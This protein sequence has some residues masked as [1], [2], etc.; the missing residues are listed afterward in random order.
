VAQAAHAAGREVVLVGR[1]MERVAQ[2]ARETGYL[3]GVQD[4]RSVESYG[5]LPPD[6][7]LA[8][9]TGSQGEPRAALAR[10]AADEHPEVALSAG[11]RVIFSSRAIPGN[12]KAV[13]QVINGLVEQGIEV[14]TDRTHL[15]HVSGHPRRDELRDMIGWVRPQALI[16]AHGEALHLA[17]HAD[18][19]RQAGVPH[20]LVC[21]NGDLVRLSP[22]PPQIIDALPAGR[23]YKD[24]SL[25]VNAESRTVAARRRLSFSGIVSVALAVRAD[26]A[27][28]ADPEIELIGLPDADAGGTAFFDIARDAVEK[29]FAT[30]PKPR[31]RDPDSLAE[32][33]RRAVRGA[34]AA[35]WNKKPICHVHVLMV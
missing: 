15:V 21:R 16:P 2:V 34:I 11:D 25:L 27:L 13:A 4:F 18:L 29:T 33:I 8:L 28:A 1:A 14:I 30:L 31:R 19:A 26:G 3:D 17:E 12:E 20:V 35:R 6:K 7:V 5:Y 10:I 24:G 23:L 22:G 32:A 9:C